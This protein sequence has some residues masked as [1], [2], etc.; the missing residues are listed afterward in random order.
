MDQTA[1]NDWSG[2]K[3]LWG[4]SAPTSVGHRDIRTVE[5]SWNCTSR[6]CVTLQKIF[7]KKNNQQGIFAAYLVN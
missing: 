1:G 2:V 4:S 6:R 5:N 3:E 7:K